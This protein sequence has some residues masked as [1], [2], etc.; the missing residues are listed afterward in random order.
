MF[1]K[2]CLVFIQ[3]T[4]SLEENHDKVEKEV[5]SLPAALKLV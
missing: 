2:K 3:Q 4:K 1:Y 5:D